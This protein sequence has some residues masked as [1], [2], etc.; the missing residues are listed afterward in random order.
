M[1][2]GEVQDSSYHYI[3]EGDF[4]NRISKGF[5]AEYKS[6][7]TFQGIWYY[8]TA[9]EDLDRADEKTVLILSPSG[10]REICEKLVNKPKVVY[11]YANSE[12]IK[13]R[14]ADRKDDPKEAERRI[15]ADY[16]D[17]KGFEL[18]ADTIIYNNI[19]ADINEVAKRLVK[20]AEGVK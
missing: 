17:F 12:T 19:G 3:T 10:C 9:W 6:F 7:P 18:E 5:F 16:I 4:M 20:F 15:S 13:K 2:K 8:G 11:L 14:L 1:R